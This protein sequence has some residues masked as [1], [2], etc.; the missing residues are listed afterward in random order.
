MTTITIINIA[1]Y[2]TPFYEDVYISTPAIKDIEH[3]AV[4]SISK[5]VKVLD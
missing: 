4:L 1:K 5:K 2:Y 3:I